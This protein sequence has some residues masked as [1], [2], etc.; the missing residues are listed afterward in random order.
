VEPNFEKSFFGPE[1]GEEFLRNRILRK[2]FVE[3]NFEKSFSGAE[4]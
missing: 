4:F 3:P 2:V 1:F